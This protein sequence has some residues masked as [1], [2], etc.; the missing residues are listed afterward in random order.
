[1]VTIEDPKIGE[2]NLTLN[3]R[4]IIIILVIRVIHAMK[5]ITKVKLNQR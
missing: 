5:T 1:M 4:D 3:R 2:S